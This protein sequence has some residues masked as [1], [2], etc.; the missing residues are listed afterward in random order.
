M[1]WCQHKL[2]ALSVHLWS[3]VFLFFVCS[4]FGGFGGPSVDGQCE[5][6]SE[7]SWFQDSVD[8]AIFSL[9][10]SWM[11]RSLLSSVGHAPAY[12]RIDIF[13]RLHLVNKCCFIG[14]QNCVWHWSWMCAYMD[15]MVSVVGLSGSCHLAILSSP[16]CV[17]HLSYLDLMVQR[18]WT[19]GRKTGYF[20]TQK[21]DK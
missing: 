16:E 20:S 1:A 13:C 17:K 14:V 6:H 3:S 21:M 8:F 2:F 9:F 4:V 12:S 5:E 19:T 10:F 18:D 7:D 15:G 11:L